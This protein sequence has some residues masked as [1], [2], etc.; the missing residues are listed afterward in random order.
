MSIQQTI[1]A[2]SSQTTGVIDGA[3]DIGLESVV[4]PALKI[5]PAAEKPLPV[6]CARP[7]R[8]V[9][10]R[11]VAPATSPSRS[12][13]VSSVRNGGLE[14]VLRALDRLALLGMV[15]AMALM[16]VLAASRANERPAAVAAQAAAR[17]DDREGFGLFKALAALGYAI[18]RPTPALNRPGSQSPRQDHDARAP[19]HFPRNH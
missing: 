13:A 18:W 10:L 3:P 9:P 14:R 2:K 6:E 12:S 16:P 8:G 5:A 4:K 19:R 15:V 7:R 1:P 11:L 17:A